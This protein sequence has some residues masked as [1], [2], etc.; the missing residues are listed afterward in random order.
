MNK[1]LSYVVVGGVSALVGAVAGYIFCKKSMQNTFDTQLAKAINKEIEDIRGTNRIKE[2][3][4]V[5]DTTAVPK[6]I[7]VDKVIN[8]IFK[9]DVTNFNPYR[10]SLLQSTCQ[11]CINRGYS[12]EEITEELEKLMAS[13]ESPTEDDDEEPAE[14]LDEEDLGETSD[15]PQKVMSEYADDPPHV[16]PLSDYRQ[17]P[18]YFD[19]VTFHYLAD[20]DTLLDD[21]DEIVDDVDGTVGDAL[22]HFDEE[23]DDGD[24][25]YC[26]NGSMGLAIEIVRM[27]TSYER[28]CGC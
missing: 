12:E 17:L 25:V 27:H 3:K 2:D 13:F 26:V 1:T 20:D 15:D 5:E 14:V 7:N 18:P 24:C 6:E 28:W 8:D 10:Y 22:V 23:E 9:L 16:I 19:F 4:K 11:K 21:Q